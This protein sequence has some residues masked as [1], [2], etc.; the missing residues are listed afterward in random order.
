M[1]KTFIITACLVLVMLY[2]CNREENTVTDRN[3]TIRDTGI[4]MDDINDFYYTE[5]FIN[6]NASYTRY[7]FYKEEGR[8]M[9]FYET[10]ER[11]DDYGP[12]TEEDRTSYGTAEIKE[13][14]WAEFFSYLKDGSV[15]NRKED[16]DDGG[17]GPWLFIYTDKGPKEGQEYHFTDY[18]LLKGFE[19]Y[20]AK[21]TDKYR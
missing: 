20:C 21:L 4:T 5:E 15:K 2:A 6:F 14:E 16:P 10:R 19:E 17:S 7:R 8:Y 12:C 1:K 13:S 3:E 11:K 9:F 18:G